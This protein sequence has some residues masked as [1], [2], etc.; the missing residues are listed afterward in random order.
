MANTIT[1]TDLPSGAVYAG[2]R[3][4]AT[5]TAAGTYTVSAGTP[6]IQAQVVEAGDL[7]TATD[8]WTI[9]DLWTYAG[10]VVVAWTTIVPTP[11]GGVFSGTLSVPLHSTWL[12]LQVRFADASAES[13]GKHQ[14]GVGYVVL[15][16]GQSNMQN[17]WAIN[18][19]VAPPADP[20]A[21]Y[22]YVN[23]ANPPAWQVPGASGLNGGDGAIA[24]VNALVPLVNAPVGIIL[25][26]VGGSALDSA[27]ASPATKYWLRTAGVSGSWPNDYVYQACADAIA[28]VGGDISSIIWLQGEQEVSSAFTNTAQYVADHTTLYGRLLA[29]TPR[30]VANL[31]FH[32][33]IIGFASYGAAVVDGIRAA[34]K[35]VGNSGNGFKL[36]PPTY[37]LPMA[38]EAPAATQHH[39]VSGYITLGHRWAAQLG[40]WLGT[41]GIFNAHPGTGPQI[42]GATRQ[43][44]YLIITVAQPPAGAFLGGT[45]GGTDLTGFS[46]ST[47]NFVSTLTP[48][49]VRAMLDFSN[50]TQ[51]AVIFASDPGKQVQLR[52]QDGQ[53]G[54]FFPVP[55]VA[56]D[57][58]GGGNP[59]GE[60]LGIPLCPTAGIIVS[61]NETPGYASNFGGVPVFPSLAGLGFD[62]LRTS[63]WNTNL[64]ENVSGKQV[65]IG[66]W[67]SEKYTWELTF[68]FL[69][70]NGAFGATSDEWQNLQNFFNQI[71]GRLSTFLYRDADDNQAV[72]QFIGIGDGVTTQFQCVRSLGTSGEATPIL[73]PNFDTNGTVFL[74]GVQTATAVYFK[75]GNNQG[76]PAGV[77]QFS[78]APPQGTIITAT[79]PYFWPCRFDD[80]KMTFTKFM[81]QLWSNK[82]VTFTS[83]KN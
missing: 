70:A 11:S 64:Q 74:N 60:G 35:T 29:L 43:G 37:D 80:D 26:A 24:L 9:T 73:A 53:P 68:D 39:T 32:V 48:L 41:P 77:L 56:N 19:G 71:A 49:S 28:A 44:K 4:N 17:L 62:V 40:Y 66:Y 33:G 21:S 14:F 47:D 46:F 83:V 15:A 23:P 51:I 81:S 65:G 38:N 69:R 1:L 5:I 34:Q 31:L 22:Y 50:L 82:K 76:Q 57:C 16:A 6:A 78:P 42:T 12:F 79:F 36:G 63:V 75:Y 2:D 72:L 59:P 8:L 67:S 54:S 52:Y 3:A 10:A 25:G 55:S 30:T 20:R 7:W 45:G 27:A 58:Y 13:D 18:S 61:G